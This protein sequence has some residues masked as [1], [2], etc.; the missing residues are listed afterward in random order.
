MISRVLIGFVILLTLG[1]SEPTTPEATDGS[2][3]F[4]LE[5]PTATS[6]LDGSVIPTVIAVCHELH[7]RYPNMDCADDFVRNSTLRIDDYPEGVA[8]VFEHRPRRGFDDDIIIV[9][10]K[11]FHI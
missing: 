4:P 10:K 9:V 11:P 1:L 7:V 8:A 2:R 5:S 3:P 6:S